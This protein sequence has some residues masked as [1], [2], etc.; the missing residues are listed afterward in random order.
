M[1]SK[2]KIPSLFS[3]TLCEQF[4]CLCAACLGAARRQARRQEVL[5]Q[6]GATIKRNLPASRLP[7]G[8]TG[9]R[10]G[11]GREVLGYGE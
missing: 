8:Q 7:V 1:M 5:A 6:A 4:A 11:A 3:A 10:F 2:Q 9:S